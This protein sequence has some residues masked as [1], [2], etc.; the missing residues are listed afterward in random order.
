MQSKKVNYN[1][2]VTSKDV[3]KLAGVSQSSVS[4]VFSSEGGRGVKP[5]VREKILKV[6]KEIGYIPNLV[7]RSMSSGKTNLIALIV[8][9]QLGPFYNKIIDLF[10][11]GIQEI[12]KQCI[13][14]KV[15]RQER[16]DDIIS[17]VIQFQVEGVIITSSAVSQV[18][19]ET[20]EGNNIPVV[21]FNKYI[22]GINIST[23]YV[24]PIEGGGLVAD[25]LLSKGHKSIG[26]IHFK[27]ETSQE[28]EKKIGFYS[29]LRQAGIYNIQEE[30]SDYDYDSGYD[31][32]KR[33]LNSENIPTA[34]FCTSDLIA[35]GVMDAA[36][37][38]YSLRVPEDISVIG[39]DDI[40]M[41][42]WKAYNLTTVRQPIEILVKEAI[43]ILKDLIKNNNSEP[44]IKMIRPELVIRKSSK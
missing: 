28:V 18:I 20:C 7:A 36:K 31:A 19:T 3:A 13:V 25:Y 22:P 43:N 12:G 39:Y 16:I 5:E 17:K 32:G 29:K 9:D 23:A 37:N 34:V 26:Y 30:N 21:L 42:S 6:A 10:V 27:N 38:E 40:K 24:D 11:E 8:G 44:V 14:F 15:P 33:L 35:M 4:R 41:A 1:K 2:S